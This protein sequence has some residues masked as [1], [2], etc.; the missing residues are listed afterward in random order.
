MTL[1]KRLKKYQVDNDL[2][3]AALAEMLEVSPGTVS[4]WMR[5]GSEPQGAY[6]EA[7]ET[8]LD[9]MDPQ[10]AP[11]TYEYIVR[12]RAPAGETWLATR[13]AV[14]TALVGEG[15]AC[16]GY[17]RPEVAMVPPSQVGVG[18]TTALADAVRGLVREEVQAALGSIRIHVD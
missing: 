7:L 9:R 3:Q 5:G 16:Y 6:L 17:S 14:L 12:V 10:A 15:P 2:S 1:I 13:S 11:V 8:F 18:K 4:R